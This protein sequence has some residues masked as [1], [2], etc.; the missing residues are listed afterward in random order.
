MEKLR[1]L[2]NSMLKIRTTST[3]MLMLSTTWSQCQNN[4]EDI[5]P[6]A[7]MKKRSR[8]KRKYLQPQPEK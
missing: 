3:L 7:R 1:S 8:F 6:E 5:L 4:I 2:H